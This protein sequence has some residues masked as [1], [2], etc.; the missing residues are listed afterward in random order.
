MYIAIDIGGTKSAFAKIDDLKNPVVKLNEMI[1]TPQDYDE[2]LNTYINTIGQICQ[3]AQPEG[4]SI[5]LPGEVRNKEIGL[6]TNLPGWKGKNLI[7]DIET[8][9]NTKV[10]ARN[11]AVATARAERYFGKAKNLNRYLFVIIGTGLG[12]TYVHKVG[13]SYLE[14][15]LEP[16]YMIINPRGARRNH[17]HTLGLL[18][19]YATGAV[20]QEKTGMNSL[21]SLENDDPLWEEMATYLGIG[22][23]N[24]VTLFKPPA[25]FFSGGIIV[26]R[27]FLLNLIRKEMA[28]YVEYLPQPE[29]YISNLGANASLYGAISLLYELQ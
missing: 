4:I 27:P 13:E 15:P 9:F 22:I 11:D 25:I 20:I 2:A 3:D 18:G 14:L 5:T 21:A 1:S 10:I 12:A 6:L 17:F 23:N 26:N 28:R 16:E 24:L 7:I 19:A 8:K 29:L